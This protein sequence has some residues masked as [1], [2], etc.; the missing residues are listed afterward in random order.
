MSN[1][2]PFP[3]HYFIR[4]IRARI[5]LVFV[6]CLLTFTVAELYDTY[7]FPKVLLII[8]ILTIISIIQGYG[9]VSPFRKILAKIDEIQVQLPHN[10]KL[11]IIYQKNEWILI[12][13]MLKLAE[14]YIREKN[15]QL[16]VSEKES[17]IIL[18]SIADP[19]VLLDS[20][21]NGKQYNRSFKNNFVKEKDIKVVKDDKLWMIFD[22]KRVLNLFEKAKEQVKVKR[23]F[24][25]QLNNEYYNI[26]VTP[27]LNENQKIIGLL[28]LFHNVTESKLTE[29]MRVDFVANV[30][31]EIRTPL[32]SIKGFSQF[33]LAQKETCPPN[34]QSSL[35]RIVHNT[36]RLQDLFDNLLKLSIIESKYELKKELFDLSKLIHTIKNNLQHKHPHKEIQISIKP[37]RPIFGDKKLLE[38]VF[39]NL[40]D[41][42]IKYSSKNVAII[43][44]ET[45]QILNKDIIIIQDNGPGIPESDLK[46]IFE[47]FYR[48]KGHNYQNKEGTGLGLSIVKHI[49][50]KHNG[51]ISVES[52]IDKGTKF[53]IELPS[54]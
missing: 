12:Q 3:W 18:E 50:N 31:H 36:E 7:V 5:T 6:S 46:R 8:F 26:S 32:T 14:R 23:L 28:G 9:R 49:I 54:T 13:E 37:S 39:T 33:L 16:Q 11:N 38:Q 24:A 29:K 53:T 22:D 17:Q 35:E 21:L 19:I 34:I 15:E 2:T 47:R 51:Q 30:S 1:Q 27:I 48:I 10:K 45:Q 4:T 41:N 42:S 43:N 40:I 20:F 52:E 44:C 25:H